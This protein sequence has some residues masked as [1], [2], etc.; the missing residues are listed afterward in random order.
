MSLAKSLLVECDILIPFVVLAMFDIADELEPGSVPKKLSKPLG[1]PS[2]SGSA[3]NAAFA[4]D[5]PLLAA[6]FAKSLATST[7]FN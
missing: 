6:Q 1:M 2:P 5:N 7:I 4:P 3:L